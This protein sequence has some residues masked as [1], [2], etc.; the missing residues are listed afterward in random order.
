MELH[1]LPPLDERSL[2]FLFSS[3]ELSIALVYFHSFWQERRQITACN[4]EGVVVDTVAGQRLIHDAQGSERASETDIQPISSCVSRRVPGIT[5]ATDIICGFPGETDEDFQQTMELVRKYRFPSLFINQFYPRPGTP[6]AKMEQVPA[7]VKKQ[8]T[9]ELS[10]L[11]HSYNPYDHKVGER[12]SVLVTEESFDAQYYVAHN[13]FYEQVLVPKK[14]EFKGKMIEVDV[15]E[16]GKHFM[17]GRPADECAVLTPSISQPLEKGAVSGLS[18]KLKASGVNGVRPPVMSP[19]PI[20]S[21]WNSDGQGLKLLS[22]QNGGV[23]TP[24]HENNVDFPHLGITWIPFCLMNTKCSLLELSEF[25]PNLPPVSPTYTSSALFEGHYVRHEECA[26][27]LPAERFRKNREELEG[28][29]GGSQN[30]ALS[31]SIT[32]QGRL[33]RTDPLIRVRWDYVKWHMRENW[34]KSERQHDLKY[35]P[36]MTQLSD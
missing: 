2:L 28:I 12:Q 33:S 29:S 21:S 13:K 1:T 34:K 36:G 35:E 8:R 23:S 32:E 24:A 15:F 10:A 16:S 20:A 30:S 6:A 25:L 22:S 17:R 4:E 7:H 26:T 3:E 19:A 14:P 5:I 31:E 18:Q 9:K 27:A 11:F